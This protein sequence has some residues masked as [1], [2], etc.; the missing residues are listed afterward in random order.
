MYQVILKSSQNAEAD[1]DPHGILW[2]GHSMYGLNDE[3]IEDMRS[4]LR[5]DPLLQRH[6]FAELARTTAFNVGELERLHEEFTFVRFHTKAYERVKL[7]GVRQEYFESLIAREF[8]TVG[9]VID[10]CAVGVGE[11]LC[12]VL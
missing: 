11:L 7:R 4:T 2:L 9:G 1:V 5:L 3:S 8:S 10:R 6:E 12:C